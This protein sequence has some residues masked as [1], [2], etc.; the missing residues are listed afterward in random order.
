MKRLDP[1]GHKCLGDQMGQAIWLTRAR[2]F[3]HGM[4]M[5]RNY[6]NRAWAGTRPIMGCACA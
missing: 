4:G 2:P 5:T 3:W 1:L 6:S